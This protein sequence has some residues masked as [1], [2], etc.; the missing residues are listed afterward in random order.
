MVV[1]FTELQDIMRRKATLFEKIITAVSH[2][3]LGRYK[4]VLFNEDIPTNKINFI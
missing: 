1:S 3:I 4:D 2:I